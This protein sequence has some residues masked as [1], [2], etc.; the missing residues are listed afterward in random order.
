MSVWKILFQEQLLLTAN[1]LQNLHMTITRQKLSI[2]L[3]DTVS[4]KNLLKQ[5]RKPHSHISKPQIKACGWPKSLSDLSIYL[6]N[7]TTQ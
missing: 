4:Q 1:T 3:G 5:D 2:T 6:K 7:C